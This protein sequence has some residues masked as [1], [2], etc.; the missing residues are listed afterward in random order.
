MHKKLR[1][2]LRISSVNVTKSGISCAVLVLHNY[3]Q[4]WKMNAPMPAVNASKS[5]KS[6]F[7]FKLHESYNFRNFMLGKI[8]FWNL[9]ITGWLIKNL[10]ASKF[11]HMF[12]FGNLQWIFIYY[13][14]ID[15]H[16]TAER[17]TWNHEAIRYLHWKKWCS[18]EIYFSKQVYVHI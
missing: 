6:H 14:I 15:L 7:C 1:F 16:G 18:K 17:F 5:C 4:F 3:N 13:F 9:L 11:I 12:L 2:S 10:V 8:E